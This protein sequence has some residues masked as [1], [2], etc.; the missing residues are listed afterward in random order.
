MHMR[1]RNKTLKRRYVR[2][3]KSATWHFRYDCSKFPTIPCPVDT[4]I[5]CKGV[6]K[7]VI[8]MRTRK[9]THGELCNECVSKAKVNA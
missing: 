8:V 6:P 5:A 1:R 4:C 7:V 9:P 3:A 2:R